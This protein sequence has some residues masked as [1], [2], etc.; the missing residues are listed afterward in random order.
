LLLALALLVG[1]SVTFDLA[2]DAP[3]VIGF[4]GVAI[5]AIV[6]ID[7]AYLEW[8]RAS[9]LAEGTLWHAEIGDLSATTTV[10]NGYTATASTRGETFTVRVSPTVKS[11]A[12]WQAKGSTRGRSSPAAGR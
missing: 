12:G 11:V 10:P 9:A 2:K 1:V 6:I 4:W 7:G 3:A 8:G 5:V